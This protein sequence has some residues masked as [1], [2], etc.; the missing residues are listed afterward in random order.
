MSNNRRG[1]ITTYGGYSPAT[2]KHYSI[3]NRDVLLV[4]GVTI[5]LGLVT[6]VGY[7][8]LVDLETQRR[9]SQG[10]CGGS[11]SQILHTGKGP[12]KALDN[13]HYVMIDS[14][15]GLIMFDEKSG[16]QV[17]GPTSFITSVRKNTDGKIIEKQKW[18]I[19]EN[20]LRHRT[21]ECIW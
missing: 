1:T 2:P 10:E 21:A 8:G 20:D 9:L 5:A 19:L 12:F 13:S 15:G 4:I 6:W 14:S 16:K 17:A 3:N 18:L 11:S 7:E